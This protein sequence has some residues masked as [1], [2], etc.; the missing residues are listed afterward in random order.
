LARLRAVLALA[1]GL[2][3]AIPALADDKD[4]LKTAIGLAKEGHY[5]QAQAI[6]QRLLATS[7]ADA[8]KLGPILL[9]RAEAYF[10]SSEYG[11]AETTLSTAQ[12][13][14]LSDALQARAAA[15]ADKIR[16]KLSW[17]HFEGS[18]TLSTVHDSRVRHRVQSVSSANGVEIIEICDDEPSGFSDSDS[19]PVVDTA[20]N[21]YFEQVTDDTKA[22]SRVRDISDWQAQTADKVEHQIALDSNGSFWRTVGELTQSWQVE[23]SDQD[24]RVV[25]VRTGPSWF[26]PTSQTRLDLSATYLSGRQNHQTNLQYFAPLTALEWRPIASL[27]LNAS[28][29]YEWRQAFPAQLNGYA[30]LL[31]SQLRW[32]ATSNDRFTARALWRQQAAQ[33]AYNSYVS[34]EFRADY[35]RGFVWFGREGGFVEA[36]MRLRF[37][38]FAGAAPSDNG[39]IRHDTTPTGLLYLGQDFGKAWTVKISCSYIDFESTIARYVR[40]DRQYYLSVTRNF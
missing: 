16:D 15:L 19:G 10:A 40:N 14:P 37:A 2:G 24:N 17:Q 38:N 26:L 21:C 12:A 23:A 36:E 33:F 27:K 8:G 4:P 3:L 20:Q 5:A 9:G 18:T 13:L 34:Q 11:L 25:K 39:L 22:G 7:G 29:Q 1:V 28:Y 30:N 32:D 31:D 6:F 35:R